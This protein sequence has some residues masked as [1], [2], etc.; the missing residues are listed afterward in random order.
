MITIAMTNSAARVSRS[1]NKGEGGS[2][3][4]SGGGGAG[5]CALLG[6]CR[7][8]PNGGLAGVNTLV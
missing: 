6:L 4:G 8:A 7:S 5:G 3:G 1:G 2:L